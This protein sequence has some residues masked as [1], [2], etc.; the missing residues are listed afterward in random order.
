MGDSWSGTLNVGDAPPFRLFRRRGRQRPTMPPSA[1][2]KESARERSNVQIGTVEEIDVISRALGIERFGNM[3][4]PITT[5][6]RRHPGFWIQDC[7]RSTGCWGRA[8]RYSVVVGISRLIATAEYT[9]QRV[10][11]YRYG[12]ILVDVVVVPLCPCCCCC[13]YLLLCC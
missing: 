12:K 9:F 7:V 8:L 4:V 3:V 11:Q 2:W 5:Q 6:S 1:S 10:D 13:C